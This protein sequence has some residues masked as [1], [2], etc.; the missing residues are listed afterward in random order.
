MQKMT[1]GHSSVHRT[2]IRTKPRYIV[3]HEYHGSQSMQ[4]A[5]RQIVENLVC[6]QFEQWMEQKSRKMSQS[7]EKR[8]GA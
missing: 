5:F 7:V 4:A 6:Q 3:V 8:P 1:Q 2:F